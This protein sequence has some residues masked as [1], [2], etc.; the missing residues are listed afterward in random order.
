MV[1]L[2]DS[3]KST[4]A[5]QPT[6]SQELLLKAALFRGQ[7]A[8]SSW[9]EWKSK[10]AS[11]EMDPLTA[12]ILPSVFQNRAHLSPSAFLNQLKS[13][14]FK[15]WYQNQL[16]IHALRG[17]LVEFSRAGIQT[18]LLKGA[19]LILCYYQ[20]YGSRPM[21]DLDVLVPREDARSS[22]VLVER[23]GWVME[24]DYDPARIVSDLHAFSF[25]RPEVGLLD[26]HWNVLW[27]CRWKGADDIFWE[28]SITS[29]M[30]G[31]SVRMLN[32]TDLLLHICVHGARIG[33]STYSYLQ[34]PIVHWIPDAI[35]V[36]SSGVAM[37]WD[38][39][40]RE[41][42]IRH[43]RLQVRSA[44]DY[45]VHVFEAP[46]PTGVLKR[47]D[48]KRAT[49]MERIHYNFTAFDHERLRPIKSLRGCWQSY[50]LELWKSRGSEGVNQMS[51]TQEAFGFLSHP[52]F[53]AYL[54]GLLPA[55]VVVF[56]R[57][58]RKLFLLVFS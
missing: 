36:L 29:E 31:Q 33:W 47:L 8:A 34:A 45:L 46:V 27:C 42:R 25:R 12:K 52:L 28:G 41:V 44:L 14:Y 50:E 35:K 10:Y 26:L 20:D 15:V 21:E 7:K 56:L 23:L 3:L 4:P 13:V 58:A 37:D 24:G 2:L 30:R 54:R 17:L 48:S 11:K 16:R 18:L 57:T 43:L 38:R 22:V 40:I 51:A 49:R 9:E 1:P 5:W 39:L 19:A 32:P 6:E 55:S 53:L